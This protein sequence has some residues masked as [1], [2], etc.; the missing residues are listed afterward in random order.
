MKEHRFTVDEMKA[1]VT[2]GKIRR[3]R[4]EEKD[5]YGAIKRSIEQG[6]DYLKLG[7]QLLPLTKRALGEDGFHVKENI[8]G[9]INEEVKVKTTITWKI[10]VE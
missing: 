8:F 5:V 2:D 6:N 10:E 7:Y 9:S 4:Q 3:Q 1:I